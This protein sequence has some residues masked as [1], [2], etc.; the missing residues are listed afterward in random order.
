MMWASC[1][2]ASFESAASDL[3][4]QASE[5]TLDVTSTDDATSTSSSTTRPPVTPSTT[6]PAETTVRT[7]TTVRAVVTTSVRPAPSSGVDDGG[8]ASADDG[9]PPAPADAEA[10]PVPE[11]T[12]SGPGR[13][14][15]IASLSQGLADPGFEGSLLGGR[16]WVEGWGDVVRQNGD[17]PMIPASNQK[18]ATALAA[19]ELL[20]PDHRMVTRVVSDSA[21]L[22]GVIDGDIVVV[23][24][25]DP[26]LEVEGEHSVGTIASLV[27]AAGVD[28]IRGDVL[29]DDRRHDRT[30]TVDGWKPDYVPESIGPLSALA[31]SGNLALE[32]DPEFDSYVLDPTEGNAGLIRDAL[33]AE[34]ITMSGG[35]GP[36]LAPVRGFELA[37]LDSLPVSE[38]IVVMLRDSD[39]VIAE[40]LTREIGLARSGQGTT[41]AGTKAIDDVLSLRL[42]PLQGYSA[43]G[44]GLS[45]ENARPPAEWWRLLEWVSRSE[46][47]DEFWAGL[48]V[49]GGEKGTLRRRFNGTP[50]QG[51]VRA[52]TGYIEDVRALSGYSQTADGR[53]VVFSL[54]ANGPAASRATTLAI[55]GLIDRL[56]GH[57]G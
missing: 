15:L 16:I 54:I 42:G 1:G 19:L 9:S 5:S 20:G 37:R 39:N 48:A 40:L 43:D 51:L 50:A 24:G 2:A 14:G 57:Q 28:R 33:V 55:D 12:A 35:V 8:L 29:I 17:I 41:R 53:M 49:G 31:I 6:A 56:A 18:L 23:G 27:R 13:D 52:K 32:H 3:P 47:K 7:E 21:P 11:V 38:L 30:R 46:W 34:G 45:R 25:G 22:R 4:A 10:Q 26:S 44:S 36:G